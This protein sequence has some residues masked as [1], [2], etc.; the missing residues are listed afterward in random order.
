M[1][2]QKNKFFL[3]NLGCKV[4]LYELACVRHDL[5]ANGFI[6]T[7]NINHANIIIINTCSVTAKADAKSRNMI[8]RALNVLTKPIVIVMGCYSQ[9]I[10]NLPNHK[11][12]PIVVG[13]Q[14]K[15][16]IVSL[17]KIK[18]YENMSLPSFVNHTRA[19]LIFQDGC[20]LMCSYCLIPYLRGRQRS[21]KHE[22]ILHEI[23]QIIKNGFKEITL[24]G[25]NLGSY[26]DC[27][28]TFYDLL[29]DL[30]KINGDFRI[31]L[32]SIEPQ[33]LSRKIIELFTKYPHRFCQH[34]HLS[35]QSANNKV[36]HD[37][38]RRYTI[39]EI[40]KLVKLIRKFNLFASIT[41]DYIVGF[42]TENN[43]TFTD[44]LKNLQKIKFA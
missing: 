5:E 41:T 32:S 29:K 23:K 4:N 42:P 1:L 6:V 10:K 24:T 28:Y 14:H 7:N 13:N 30:N 26:N 39:E 31:R 38:H 9:Q 2:K 27:G 35:L 16:K 11:K 25:I 37:M 34:Y 33:Y 19:F 36:L 44:A 43:Q 40:V 21:K 20:N 22:L 15:T 18:N 12:I 3:I 17:L 8:N